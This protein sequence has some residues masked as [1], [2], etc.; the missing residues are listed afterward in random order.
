MVLQTIRRG[1][2]NLSEYGDRRPSE[3]L[4]GHLRSSRTRVLWED[5]DRQ[6]LQSIIDRTRAVTA[7]QMLV[8]HHKL[9]CKG[10]EIR[11]G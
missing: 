1:L 9:A 5:V 7:N 11:P 3:S 10:T 2:S 6:T 4:A 8:L